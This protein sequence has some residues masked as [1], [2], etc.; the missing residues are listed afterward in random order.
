MPT[1]GTTG[2]PKIVKLTYENLNHNTKAI[3]KYLKLNTK[4]ITITTLPVSYTYGMSILNTFIFSGAKLIVT[5]CNIFDKF[6]DDLL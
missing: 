6:F 3:S 1:S 5:K 2:N 4:K